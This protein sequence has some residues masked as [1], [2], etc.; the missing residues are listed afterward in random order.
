[1]GEHAQGRGST[2][3]LQPP[4]TPARFN[5][6]DHDYDA[7]ADD[8]HDD[9]AAPDYDHN[10]DAAAH[11]DHDA[12][13]TTTTTTPQPSIT[14]VKHGFRTGLEDIR[15]GV[16]VSAVFEIRNS[17]AID[18]ELLFSTVYALDAGGQ[19]IL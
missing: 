17:G 11:Y 12:A 14:V 19:R 1:M 2:G 10:Y 13:P 8:Y 5:A 9:N 16:Y 3:S 6:V 15:Q 4:A 7:A 18:T